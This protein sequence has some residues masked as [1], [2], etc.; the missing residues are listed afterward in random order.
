VQ[1]LHGF[2]GGTMIIGILLTA[3]TA[4]PQPNLDFH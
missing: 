3:A 4:F 2:D 1:V